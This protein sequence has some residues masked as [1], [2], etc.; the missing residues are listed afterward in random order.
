MKYRETLLWVNSLG[1]YQPATSLNN[2]KGKIK[3]GNAKYVSVGYAKPINNI[4]K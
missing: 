4:Y 1:Q 3:N 2:F